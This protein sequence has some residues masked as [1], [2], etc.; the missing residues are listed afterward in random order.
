MMLDKGKKK[1]FAVEGKAAADA[2]V[3]EGINF[4]FAAELTC[5]DINAH[6]RC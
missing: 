3:A 4:P 1:D 2:V 5:A 6:G